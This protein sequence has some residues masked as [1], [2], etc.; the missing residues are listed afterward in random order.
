MRYTSYIWSLGQLLIFTLSVVSNWYDP[1]VYGLSILS[2][3]MVLDKLGKGIVLREI[4][5]LH[6][7]FICLLMPLVGYLIYNRTN[8]LALV[9]VRYM[10]INKEIY[11]NFCLPAVCGFCMLLCWPLTRENK[12]DFGAPL[13]K[14]I[15]NI[16]NQLAGNQRIGIYLLTVGV[17]TNT[18]VH[19]VPAFLQY[20]FTLVYFSAFAGLLYVFFAGKFAY[21]RVI[22]IAFGLFIIGVALRSGMFTI[23]AYMGMTLFSFFFI[24]MKASMLRKTI[25]F[26]AAFL[27][28]AIIQSVKPAYRHQISRNPD[29]N[30][31]QIFA[32]LVKK[33]LNSMDNIVSPN[34]YFFLYYRANQGYNVGLVMRNMP[35][36]TPHD[37]GSY[38]LV[39]IAA[40]FVPRLLWPTKPEAG[41][42]A[43]MKYYAN[44]TIVGFATDVGPLGEAY[45]SFGVVG[46]VIYMM[47]LGLFIRF[48]YGRLFLIAQKL[49]L[50][51][52]WIPVMFYQVTYSSE[53]DTLQI[54]NSLI[55]SAFFIFLLYRFLPKLFRPDKKNVANISSTTGGYSKLNTSQ[56]I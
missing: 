46:G 1:L 52:L 18:F 55:K 40:A 17:I 19:Y 49:P 33:R 27:L 24:G 8:T 48:V 15:A 34:N 38:L 54:L 39:K 32:S 43:N 29:G 12:S 23:I 16:G 11:F 56:N 36:A 10:P 13:K 44:V 45:G 14:I 2:V 20:V 51:I 25:Y 3:L 26:L 37:N 42:I 4:I 6:A 28:L 53:N 31:A 30:K 35:D 5:A 47:L 50:I 22:L 21:R 41:G 9:W 7:V